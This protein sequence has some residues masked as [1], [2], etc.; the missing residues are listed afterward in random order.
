MARYLHHVIIFT[1]IG[2]SKMI[3]YILA[4]TL[5][6]IGFVTSY[7]VSAG[8]VFNWVNEAPASAVAN[9]YR[10]LPGAG[11]VEI[12]NS[13]FLL[14]QTVLQS[15]FGANITLPGSNPPPYQV[16]IR[17][18]DVTVTWRSR[19]TGL[20]VPVANC[21]VPLTCTPVFSSTKVLSAQIGF[22]DA[23]IRAGHNWAEA[24]AG[25]QP[26]S[27][28][29]FSLIGSDLIWGVGA[30][31]GGWG[32]AGLIGGVPTYSN[33]SLAVSGRWVLDPQLSQ[34]RYPQLCS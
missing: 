30:T 29:N 26:Y 23:G 3:R 27:A 5:A 15:E 9:P 24:V 34:S 8:V 2:F 33:D 16:D 21:N 25:G 6:A 4:A 32:Y 28:N 31:T 18:A 1:L 10:T 17:S 7:G 11:R 12:E 20:I 13:V 19:A 14:A 22:T